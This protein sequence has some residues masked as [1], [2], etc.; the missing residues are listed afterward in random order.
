MCTFQGPD[1]QRHHQNSTRRHPG[2][3]RERKKE[4]EWGRER[5]KQERKFG[6]FGVGWSGA[7]WSRGQHQNRQWR[8]EAKPRISVAPKVGGGGAKGPRGWGP[9]GWAPKGRAPFSPGLGFRSVGFGFRSEC[10]SLGLWGLGFVASENLAKTLKLAKVGL[11]KVGHDFLRSP[12][13]LSENS[14]ALN[15]IASEWKRQT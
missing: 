3:E 7:G 4:R 2:R 6:R 1:L 9:E 15:V 13:N 10:R 12:G 11:A 8:V 5:E 14:C